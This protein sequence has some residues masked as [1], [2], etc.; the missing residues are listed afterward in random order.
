MKRFPMIAGT[1]ALTLYL[2]GCASVLHLPPIPEA[3]SSPPSPQ[4]LA[5]SAN[6]ALWGFFTQMPGASYLTTR[7]GGQ[8]LTWRWLKPGQVMEE[9]WAMINSDT[10]TQT[11]TMWRGEQP[12]ELY[13]KTPGAVANAWKGYVQS[14]GSV[15]FEGL[16]MMAVSFQV[17][18]TQD[19]AI[20]VRGADIQN[21]AL[22]S[23]SPLQPAD[24]YALERAAPATAPKTTLRNASGKPP[25]TAPSPS[26]PKASTSSDPTS[27][28]TAQ[29]ARDERARQASAATAQAQQ[30]LDAARQQLSDAQTASE[31]A[32][33][34]AKTL[35][36]QLSPP[37]AKGKGGPVSK[38]GDFWSYCYYIVLNHDG[39]PTQY[40]LSNLI[41]QR[42]YA[43]P[44]PSNS[45]KAQD[46]LDAYQGPNTPYAVQ[47]RFARAIETSG[48]I[49]SD[50]LARSYR[51]ETHIS[52]HFARS[53]YQDRGD[54]PPPTYVTWNRLEDEQ[55][56]GYTQT[57][58]REELEQARKEAEQARKELLS[59]QEGLR[60]QERRLKLLQE[61]E[62]RVRDCAAG[63]TSSCGARGTKN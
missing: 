3:S 38:N 55:L 20:E 8:R 57:A 56:A 19:G 9:N 18:R 13:L 63:K 34:K 21:G 36:A 31:A 41:N 7:N 5:D 22:Q 50:S 46:E 26:A 33:S 58:T 48:L 59:A 28:S 49:K 35:A 6:P 40:F 51:C 27:A 2:S 25:A 42:I 47:N 23:L 60:Q 16:N 1:L 29:A 52:L 10:P 17:L 15:L 11:Y 4:E 30:Q 39:K 61:D 24:R 32:Q 44:Y 14:D 62:Q 37:N 45:Q 12:G 54:N 43:Y 53:Y